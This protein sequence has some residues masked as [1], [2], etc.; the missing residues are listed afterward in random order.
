MFIDSARITAQGGDGGRGC[1]S[2]RR[3]KYIPRGGP[4]GGDGGDGG[5]VALRATSSS[6]TLLEF[7]YRRI[8][9]AKRGGHGLG[10][11]QHGPR[12]EDVRFDGPA[13]TVVTDEDT[14]EALADLAE[15]GRETVVAHGGRGGKGNARFKSSTRRAPRFA[16]T[17]QPG[18]SRC[19]LLELRLLADVGIIG[20]PNAGKSSLLTRISDSRPRIADYP[21]STLEPVLGVVH[22]GDYESFVAADLPGLIE[23][24]HR[25]KGLGSQF[26]QHVRRTRVLVHVV[27]MHPP[28]GAPADAFRG[29]SAELTQYD[30]SLADK[31][32]LVAANKIDLPGAR[33]AM[34]EFMRAAGLSEVCPISAA[35]GEGVSELLQAVRGVL[36][37]EEASVS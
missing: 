25:G 29:V 36:S 16:Q 20:A 11:D 33:E 5:D 13:G 14:G 2:F 6:S 24:A 3:E 19:L 27:E 9:R 34:V 15:A 12:G 30:E 22:V 32:V 7:R 37:R 31:P 4:D 10:K 23:G 18:E 8:I 1:V 17:G 35:T 28:E 26:L 21:F